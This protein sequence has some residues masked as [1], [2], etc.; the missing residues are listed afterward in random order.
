MLLPPAYSPP[1]ALKH[2]HSNKKWMA[3]GGLS[4]FKGVNNDQEAREARAAVSLKKLLHASMVAT[5]VG[6]SH[7]EATD[8]W[9]EAWSDPTY[10]AWNDF[11]G[12]ELEPLLRT[13]PRQLGNS[14]GIN[15]PLRLVDAR[16][17]ISLH[18]HGKRLPRR[19]QIPE[20]AF[21]DLNALRHMPEGYARSLRII[22][23]SYVRPGR[24]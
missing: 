21:I 16:Y 23:I 2:Q 10:K 14:E 13:A 5:S 11:A 9:G 18:E 3:M 24:F 19:Q 22:A 20:H 12:A 7:V 15:A 8:L 4:L 17:I 1:A 6:A